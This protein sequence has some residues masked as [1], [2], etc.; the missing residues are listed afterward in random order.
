MSDSG[1]E[2]RPKR[3][4]PPAPGDDPWA[5]WRKPEAPVAAPA[6]EPPRRA[7]SPAAGPAAVDTE[8]QAA[9][10]RTSQGCDTRSARRSEC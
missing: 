8:I 7:A 5:K 2:R 4:L 1:S 6:G 10:G 3:A 9:S